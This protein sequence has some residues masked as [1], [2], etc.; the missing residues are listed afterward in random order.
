MGTNFDIWGQTLIFQ[1]WYF[2]DKN[3]I[4]PYSKEKLPNKTTVDNPKDKVSDLLV[5]FLNKIRFFL[6]TVSEMCNIGKHSHAGF[7]GSFLIFPF[8]D[9]MTY[10]FLAL[11]VKI[12]DV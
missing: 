2:N 11:K 12:S 1:K 10:V 9:I 6:D 4:F 3:R 5:N 7:V 8:M